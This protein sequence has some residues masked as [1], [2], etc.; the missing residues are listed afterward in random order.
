M[1][2]QM[3]FTQGDNHGGQV[4]GSGLQIND[5]TYYPRGPVAHR[6]S[7]AAGDCPGPGKAPEYTAF[8]HEEAHY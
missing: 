8:H 5:P 6:A 3:D 2:L 1:S 4:F 7:V